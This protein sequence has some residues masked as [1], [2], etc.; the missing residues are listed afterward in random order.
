M[1]LM[2]FSPNISIM[3]LEDSGRP[4][5]EGS[6]QFQHWRFAPEQIGTIRRSLNEA[7]VATIR[8]KF[9]AAEVRDCFLFMFTLVLLSWP[10]QARHPGCLF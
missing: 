9:E 8:Q 7:A 6:T 1:N 10:S 4:L 2:T 3:D 5:Y